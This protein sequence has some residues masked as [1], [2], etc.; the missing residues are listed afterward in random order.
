MIT[1]KR[2]TSLLIRLDPRHRGGLQRQIYASIQRAILDGVV[3]PGDAPAL[4]AR[5][6]RRPRR[7]SAPPRCSRCSSSRR[8][9]TSPGAAAPAPSWPTSCPDDLP[10]RRTARPV[11]RLKHPNLSRRGA[12]LVA[13]PRAPTVSRA[14]R[15]HS[16]SE[17]P[18]W[19][20]SRWRSGGGSRVG[21]SARS[22][23]P[24]STTASRPAFARCA[25]PSPPTSPA[26]GTRFERRPGADR[27]RC[28]ARPRADQPRAARPG[29]SGLD[30]GAGLPGRAQRAAGGGRAHPPGPGGRRGPRGR[31]GRAARGRCA[32]GLRDAV[33]PVSAGRA[34]EPAA[35]AGPAAVGEPRAARG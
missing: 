22:R 15:A 19:T 26:R 17:P 18:E 16:A 12:A 13:A 5:P 4:L 24:S 29:R 9:A 25:R 35:A 20:C 32:P 14:R 7:V 30:G 31:D 2:S 11:A 27:G 3:G 28:A 33:A 34:D 1:S 8:R 10:R 6:G 23:R 21:G